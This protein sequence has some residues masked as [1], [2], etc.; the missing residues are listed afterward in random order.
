MIQET[1]MDKEWLENQYWNQ[2]KSI[3]KI[4]DEN[5]SNYAFILSQLKEFNI[6]RRTKSEASNNR[7]KKNYMFDKH[8]SIEAKKKIG[9]AQKGKKNS[10]WRGG[11][12][13]DSNGYILVLKPDHPNS[14]FNGYVFEHRLV[15]EEHLERYLTKEE[16]VHHINGITIDNKIENLKLIKN[17]AEH[18][19]LESYN[20]IRNGLG[21]FA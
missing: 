14:H 2:K 7:Q 1:K 13:K 10:N 15:M 3:R 5:N 16:V 19:R 21:Q 4:A 17:K 20:R 8:H 12:F 11:R 18:S 9:E 6:P